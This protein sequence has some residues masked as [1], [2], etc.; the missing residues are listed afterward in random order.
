MIKPSLTESASRVFPLTLR[1][2][3]VNPGLIETEGSHSAGAMNSDFQTWNEKQTP[4]GRIGQVQD[5]API[6]AFLASDDAGWITGEVIVA[7][8]GMR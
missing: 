3:S 8:G 5:V 2:I 4:L 6:V 7:A 1:C